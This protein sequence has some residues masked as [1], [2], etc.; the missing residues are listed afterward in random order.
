MK[1]QLLQ[2]HND[3]FSKTLDNALWDRVDKI[4]VVDLLKKIKL[5]AAVRQSNNVNMLAMMSTM[6]KSLP[7]Q[8]QG[9][10]GGQVGQDVPHQQV[11]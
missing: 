8:T 2:G 1:D 5:L 7:L 4:S 10:G 3:T 11:E 9:V 6:Q